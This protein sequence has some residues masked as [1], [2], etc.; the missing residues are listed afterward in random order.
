MY[1]I[2]FQNVC[3]FL[4]SLLLIKINRTQIK[5]YKKRFRMH[6]IVIFQIKYKMI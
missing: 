5:L 6:S 1:K 3:V 4:A 2:L